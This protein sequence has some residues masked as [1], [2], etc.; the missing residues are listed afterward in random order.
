MLSTIKKNFIYFLLFFIFL[1]H[2]NT[3][4]NFFPNENG[5]LGHDF[6]YFMPNFLF[7]KIWFEKNFLNIPWFSPSFCCGI[8]FYPDP[9]TM[10]FSIQQ[11]FYIIFEKLT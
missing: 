10:F 9:Q 3:Y 8:P 11:I 7:G 5:F 2:Q 6:E 1:I 4:L